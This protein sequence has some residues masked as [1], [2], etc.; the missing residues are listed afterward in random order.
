MISVNIPRLRK[1][2]NMMAITKN[3]FN[4][5]MKLKIAERI[6]LINLSNRIISSWK[7]KLKKPIK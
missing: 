7:N 3:N 6:M 1:I 2:I 4:I 5:K